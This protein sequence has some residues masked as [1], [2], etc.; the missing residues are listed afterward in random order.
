MT[1]AH[2]FA[3]AVAAVLALAAVSATAFA[4]DDPTGV[5]IDDNGRGAVEIAACGS[6]KLCGRVVW[7]KSAKDSKGCGEQILGNVRDSGG[8][9]WSQGWIYSPDHDRKFDV[10]LK[11]IGDNKL[12]VVGFAG[13]KL[14]SETHYWKLAPAD[15]ERCD[16]QR[17]AAD[18]PISTG[19]LPATAS[20]SR[21]TA[22]A[23]DAYAS[24]NTVEGDPAPDKVAS[25]E[26]VTSADGSDADNRDSKSG[27]L[28][29]LENFFKKSGSTCRL[30]TP[31]L[32]VKFNCK[33]M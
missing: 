25:A 3:K 6:G 23:R 33:D 27:G 4:A 28:P 20:T 31:W 32:Q 7:V 15:L 22:P 21:D 24:K 5:W 30:D 29:A 14:F 16:G 12:R 9:L 1:T 17:A 26:P 8:G 11:R 10:E 2:G 13:I 18:A 19:S